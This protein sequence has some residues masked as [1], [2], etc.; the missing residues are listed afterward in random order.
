MCI[1]AHS[2]RWLATDGP[3]PAMLCQ[4]GLQS[5]VA[6]MVE[7]QQSKLDAVRQQLG[8]AAQGSHDAAAALQQQTL[9]LQSQLSKATEATTRALN[10]TAGVAWKCTQV[11]WLLW[12]YINAV[13][14]LCLEAEAINEEVSSKW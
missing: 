10:D 1:L 9:D 2:E 4:Q 13:T 5:T 11:N 14:T 12:H 3:S 8:T 6:G 7:A